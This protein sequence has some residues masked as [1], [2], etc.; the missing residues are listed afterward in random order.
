MKVLIAD[1]NQYALMYFS[2]LLEGK[3]KEFALIGQARDGEQAWMIFQ[4]EHP[5][6]IITDIQMP[7][8]TGI[9]LTEKVLAV[10]PET[11]I[12]F[13]SSYEE[14]QYAK[15]AVQLGVS[16]YLLKHEITREILISKLQEAA[17]RIQKKEAK[18]KYVNEGYLNER[19]F[20]PSSPDKLT[21]SANERRP[22]ECS[23][24]CLVMEDCIYPEF[25]A[26]TAAKEK[27]VPFSSLRSF[28]YE[29]PEVLATVKTADTQI[30]LWISRK[31]LDNLLREMSQAYTRRFASTATFIKILENGKLKDG[32]SVLREL[33]PMLSGKIF[34]PASS[35]LSSRQLFLPEHKI[36]V[37]AE[38]LEDDINT[39]QYD[40][41]YS[42]MSVLMPSA[43]RV[44][45]LASFQ[46]L[47]TLS[48]RLL[49]W[50]SRNVYDSSTRMLFTLTGIQTGTFWYDADSITGWVLRQLKRLADFHQQV[51]GNRHSV[52]A[53]AL[54]RYILQH[55][56]NEDL[57]V[58]GIADALHVSVNGL[59]QAAKSAYSMTVNKII[60]QVR[61][62]SASRILKD[63]QISVSSI[64][65]Q[66]GYH[67]VS[68]FSN[69]FR[70]Y[71]GISPQEYRRRHLLSQ[72]V[73]KDPSAA[74]VTSCMSSNE[75]SR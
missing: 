35:I 44:H 68:Y 19:I 29:Y 63:G 24:L 9:E 40:H 49:T 64:A 15:S 74:Q 23:S 31:P 33:S 66:T 37:P 69:A 27:P 53:D 25:E 10:A 58:E 20:S 50:A 60:T 30:V 4:K 13:L 34:F 12:L 67:S 2:S 14:F 52:K 62:E 26:L 39:S 51:D 32:I 42:S 75:N 28:F 71:Y 16:D 38:I 56:M 18:N 17:I 73:A 48:V 3:E 36:T 45:D 46:Y 6:I 59:N 43:I 65:V 70:K 22:E 21:V 5:Q 72:T 8:L 55:Y 61:M 54:M 41:L 11:E 7:V 1:D 47:C 57:S